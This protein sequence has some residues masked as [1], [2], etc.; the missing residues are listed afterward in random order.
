MLLPHAST[1]S[2]SKYPDRQLWLTSACL[3]ALIFLVLLSWAITLISQIDWSLKVEDRPQ[4]EEQAVTVR[5]LE[6][7][8]AKPEELNP[9]LPDRKPFARTSPD[10]PSSKQKNNEFIGERSTQ[11]TSD[12]PADPTAEPLPSQ[13]GVE[14]KPGELETTES[15][16][17]DGELVP[18]ASTPLQPPSSVDTLPPSPPNPAKPNAQP[19]LRENPNQN[20][21][22]E[23]SINP[24]EER[25]PP[26]LKE[27]LLD[28]PNPVEVKVQ[29]DEGE[30][31]RP[32]QT[33][34]RPEN[35]TELTDASELPTPES[36]P[37]EQS[38]SET[39]R[40]TS[41]TP[42]TDRPFQGNQRKTAIVGSISRTGRSA[43]NVDDTELGRY[44]AAVGK[45]V[46]LE[47]QRHCLRNQDLIEPG[48]LSVRVFVEP[49]GRVRSM[50]TVGEAL[51]G[52]TQKGFTLQAIREADIPKMP[53]SLA[54]IYEGE[55]LELV[56]RFHF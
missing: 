54:E 49:S 43:L 41:T 42:P 5:F 50:S 8:S 14:P 17:Q 2:T 6:P 15:R 31:D 3:A 16:Y 24:S 44:Q 28:G 37:A 23:P 20:L 34:S 40:E 4:P 27:T 10:Q 47:W 32:R 36:T 33:P 22:R 1:I 25:T 7:A 45:A 51:T 30:A 21:S 46:E 26:P 18:A 19:Q 13:T 48:F 55:T 53:K 56:Y 38:V 9:S 35:R 52:E 11:A 39:P 29:E 12:R